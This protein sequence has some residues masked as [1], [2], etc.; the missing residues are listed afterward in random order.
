MCRPILSSLLPD[1]WISGGKGQFRPLQ[2]GQRS[3]LIGSTAQ[4]NGSVTPRTDRG[5]IKNELTGTPMI[6]PYGSA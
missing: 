3:F 1:L 4:R 6:G 2:E 5:N